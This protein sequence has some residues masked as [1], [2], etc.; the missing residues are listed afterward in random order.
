MGNHDTRVTGAQFIEQY[1]ED[2]YLFDVN[3]KYISWSV[4]RTREKSDVSN[5]RDEYI[6]YLPKK[7][8]FFLFYTFISYM[9]C[10][11]P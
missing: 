7:V 5:S 9:Q 8:I 10:L 3:T 2:I 6:W 4:L 1:I 11:T